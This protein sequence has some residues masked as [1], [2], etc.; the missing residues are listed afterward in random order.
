MT[1]EMN[2]ISSNILIGPGI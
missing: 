2:L 1:T